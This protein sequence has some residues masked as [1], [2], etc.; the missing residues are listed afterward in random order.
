MST[1]SSTSSSSVIAD[2]E[3]NKFI[4]NDF[5]SDCLTI[6]SYFYNRSIPTRLIS[7]VFWRNH[8]VHS[9]EVE[10]EYYDSSFL[11]KLKWFVT[12]KKLIQYDHPQS[13][14]WLK[15]DS[16]LQRVIR[17]FQGNANRMKNYYLFNLYETLISSF[18]IGFNSTLLLTHCQHVIGYTSALYEEKSTPFLRLLETCADNMNYRNKRFAVLLYRSVLDY[19]EYDSPSDTA[20][21]SLLEDSVL[22]KLAKIKIEIQDEQDEQIRA[23]YNHITIK[24]E[25]GINSIDYAFALYLSASTCMTNTTYLKQ[26]EEAENWLKRSIQILFKNPPN[27]DFTPTLPLLLL[28]QIR[29]SYRDFKQAELYLDQACLIDYEKNWHVV[30][31][32]A[33]DLYIQIGLPFKAILCYLK[34]LKYYLV[35]LEESKEQIVLCANRISELYSDLELDTQ[36]QHVRKELTLIQPP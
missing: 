30:Q 5:E 15:M 20:E 13:Q 17:T 9:V 1:S 26:E 24:Y 4:L 2:P 35:H 6:C 21:N 33:A 32:R 10:E 22:I 7:G 8:G 28:V 14:E 29:I 19:I 34:A 12:E 25:K 11:P 18:G 31:I 16:E 27:L 23:V 36:K 3:R